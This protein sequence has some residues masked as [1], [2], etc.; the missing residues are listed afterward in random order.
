MFVGIDVAKAELVVVSRPTLDSVLVANDDTGVRSL[1]SR[2]GRE[3]PTLI[4]VEATGGYE[5]P[6]VAALAAAGLPIV[7]VNPRQ[8]RDFAKSIGQLAKTDRIDAGVLALFAE[9][10][11]PALTVVPDETTREL[12][13]VVTRRRQLVE[14]LTAEK[15]RL[16]QATGRSQRTSKKSLKKHI[17]FLERELA[18]TDTDLHTMV[19]QRSGMAG[20]R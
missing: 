6:L 8:V 11:R 17:A 19:R 1:V 15:N 18:M 16:G 20:A 9:R 2:W 13:A 5:M 7:V 12:D 4:V 14:M 3:A 10:V